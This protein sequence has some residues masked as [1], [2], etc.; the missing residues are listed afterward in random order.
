VFGL[1]AGVGGDV[2]GRVDLVGQ[3]DAVRPYGSELPIARRGDGS[4]DTAP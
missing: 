4:R 2:V 1:D 3:F